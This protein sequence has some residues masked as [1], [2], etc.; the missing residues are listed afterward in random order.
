MMN[1]FNIISLLIS[2]VALAL[3]V[4][5][6][7]GKSKIA[8]VD[9]AEVYKE[10]ELSKELQDK[11][12]KSAMV[13]NTILDSLRFSINLITK[14]LDVIKNTSQREA[15]IQKYT[16]KASEFQLREEQLRKDNDQQ[17]QTYKGQIQTQLN[18]YITEFGKENEFDL[19]IGANGTGTLLYASDRQNITK[20]LIKYIRTPHTKFPSNTLTFNFT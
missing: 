14:Q 3:S 20:E 13:R 15:L 6:Y 11:Y 1:K 17:N 2:L 7:T 8:Y 16:E 18:Q 19:M 5:L 4:Y 9:V 12:A 10:F